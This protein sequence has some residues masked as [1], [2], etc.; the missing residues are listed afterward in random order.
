M[1]MRLPEEGI[2]FHRLSEQVYTTLLQA[3]A[4]HQ[5]RPGERLV[6]D[7]LAARLKVSRTPIRDAL[8]RLAAEGLVKPNGRRGF[9]MTSLSAQELTHLYD[10]RLM[11]ELHAVEKGAATVPDGLLAKMRA[12]A[13]EFARLTSCGDPDPT[14][15]VLY[16]LRDRELHQLIV[17]MAQNPH[18]TEF[19]KRLSIH[20]HSL[21]AGLGPDAPNVPGANRSEHAAI[22][23]AL[24]RRDREAAKEAARVHLQNAEK[25][26]LAALALEQ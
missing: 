1:R 13:D 10:L 26:A 5:I 4:D 23:E 7:D 2:D 19:F 21:R 18:L 6:L 20:I 3:I 8:S 9:Y 11:C 22:L 25:R 15:R 14:V 12:A 17:D 24:Q 16:T